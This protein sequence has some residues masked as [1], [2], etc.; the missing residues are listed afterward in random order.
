[1]I[2]INLSEKHARELLNHVGWDSKLPEHLTLEL[3]RQLEHKLTPSSTSA[4]E[5]AVWRHENGLTEMEVERWKR[6]HEVMAW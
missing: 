1:M 4:A 6:K 3:F 5:L 2:T